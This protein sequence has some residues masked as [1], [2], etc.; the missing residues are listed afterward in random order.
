M[1]TLL[2]TAELA[3]AVL[4]TSFISGI[5]GMAGGMILIAVLMAIM[6]LTVAM[7]L[8]GITQLTANSWRAW[9]WWS[10]I[11]WRIAT[12]YAA[13]ALAAAL[14][15]AAV[16]LV[17]SKPGALITL[18]L[19]SFA[20]LCVPRAIAPDIRKSGHGICCG[21]L[22][23]ALQLTAGVSGPVLDVFF[24][25]S[26]L[27]RRQTVATKAAIQALGHFLKVVYFGQLLVAGT[28][29]L[30]PTAVALSITLAAVGT[31]LS[32][33]AVDAISDAHF[34]RWSRWLIVATAATCLIQGIAQLDDGARPLAAATPTERQTSQNEHEQAVAPAS[35]DAGRPERFQTFDLNRH[36]GSRGSRGGRALHMPA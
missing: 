5:F 1:I 12:F 23:T 25:R 17:P 9:I 19:L 26:G 11:R 6:P 21:F 30:A 3:T 20:G 2:F 34:M 10:A 13:G 29:V 14:L 16:E 4:A 15:L 35:S 28:D 27:D 32:R 33:R 31:Q 36:P 18:A 22:C 8:H 7:V 24:V